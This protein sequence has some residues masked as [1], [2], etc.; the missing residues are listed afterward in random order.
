[1]TVKECH[2]NGKQRYVVVDGATGA[3]LD[4]ANGY[5]YKTEKNALRAYYYKLYSPNYRNRSWR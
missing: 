3:V 4:D 2:I 5:G 1:M